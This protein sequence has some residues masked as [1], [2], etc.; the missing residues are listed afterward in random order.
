MTENREE[1]CIS[2]LQRVAELL[3]KSP[4]CAEF[5]SA[6]TSLSKSIIRR[7]FGTWNNAKEAAGLEKYN[8]SED[9]SRATN[10]WIRE[11]KSDM[12]CLRCGEDFYR[13]LC[14][15]HPP[16]VGKKDSVSRLVGQGYSKDV[17]TDEIEKCVVLCSNCH[18][19]LHADD[20]AFSL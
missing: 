7:E 15:H 20:H 5:R 6:E 18:R 19:K 1:E 3:G 8:P 10:S 16:D 2:E 4:T 11:L 13:A 17:V 12:E 14:F 9:G